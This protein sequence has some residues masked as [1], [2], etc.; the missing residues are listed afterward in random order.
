MTITVRVKAFATLTQH[1]PD[2]M[3]GQPMEINLPASATIQMLVEQIGLPR[4]EVKV[5]FVNG[6]ARPPDWELADGDEIGIFP[7]VGGG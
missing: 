7:P 1:L 2:A 3:P 4:G 6:R 5:V